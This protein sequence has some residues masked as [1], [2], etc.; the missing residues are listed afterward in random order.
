ML[1]KIWPML[2]AAAAGSLMAVQGSMNSVLSK[3]IGLMR[4][5]FVVQLTGTV[6]VLAALA[7][8][9]GKG[10]WG[11]WTEAPWYTFSGGFLG[12]LIVYGVAASIPRV[13]VAIAT[14]AIVVAQVTTAL[15]ID[16]FGLFGLKEIPFTWWKAAGLVL[17]AVGTKLMLN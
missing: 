1:T 12:V 2:I 6:I 11:R 16:H 14:T 9:L 8:G 3:F 13:G 17:L 15:V 10:S 4:A 7:V 5:T